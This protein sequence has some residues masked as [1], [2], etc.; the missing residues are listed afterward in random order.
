M[1]RESVSKSFKLLSRRGLVPT[2]GV[3]D[4]DQIESDGGVPDEAREID[5]VLLTHID[6]THADVRKVHAFLLGKRVAAG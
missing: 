2:R 3:G 5:R 6:A 4:V 1:A